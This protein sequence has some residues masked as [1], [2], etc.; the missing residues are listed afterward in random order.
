MTT[1]YIIMLLS[2]FFWLF[3]PIRQFKTELFWY[4]FI[5][6]ISDPISVGLV[7][8]GILSQLIGY[9]IAGFLLVFS[10]YGS[11]Y[12]NW[13]VRSILLV[14]LIALIPVFFTSMNYHY[15]IIITLHIVIL[16]FF[17]RR[18]IYFIAVHS[19]LN[20][21]NIMLVLYELSILLK[22]VTLLANAKTGVAFFYIT[23][24]FQILI[25]IFFSIFKENDS[26]LFINLKNV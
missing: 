9:A 21:F 7:M 22:V 25:A 11:Y 18:S 26:R 19:K 6:A 1:F 4:F 3:P 16:F 8:A 20:I 2:M 14:L 13:H 17:L 24:I 5:L 10:L 23:D 15:G 12:K